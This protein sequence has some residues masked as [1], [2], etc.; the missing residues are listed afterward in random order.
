[1]RLM[2]N[3]LL[4]ITLLMLCLLAP[5]PAPAKPGRPLVGHVMA[6]LAVFEEAD[7]LPP[8]SSPEA[9]TI[10][11]ALIQI[12][13]ALTKTTSRATQAWFAEALRGAGEH[14]T[15]LDPH[16]GL[17]SRA[18]EAILQHAVSHPLGTRPQVLAGLQAF[19]IDQTDFELLSR[20]F[21]QARSRL[22]S[23][24]QDVHQLYERQRRVMPF[25]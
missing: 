15:A 4:P 17:T 22:L 24:G 16:D 8:E 7:V 6:L 25:Q 1:M 11:H 21:V 18:L 3:I 23:S 9:N 12:Q 5:A 19:N 13:A 20:L 2:K 14:G 10:V